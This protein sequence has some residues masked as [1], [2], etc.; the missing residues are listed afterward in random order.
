MEGNFGARKMAGGGGVP[1]CYC[2]VPVV[3]QPSTTSFN[4]G[5]RFFGCKRYGNV[6]IGNVILL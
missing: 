3:L 4:P 1:L 5:R 6:M 2:G